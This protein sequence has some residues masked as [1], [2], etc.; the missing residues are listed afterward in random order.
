MSLIYWRKQQET[1][2]GLVSAVRSRENLHHTNGGPLS[3]AAEVMVWVEDEGEGWWEDL[4]V[5]HPADAHDVFKYVVGA[6]AAGH[7]L[8]KIWDGLH[9]LL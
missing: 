3:A 5:G 1:P 4:W 8:E 9:G 7:S 6:A 2:I